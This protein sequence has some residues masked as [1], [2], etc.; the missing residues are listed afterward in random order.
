M[1]WEQLADI[2]NE[3]RQLAQDERDRDPVACPNCGEPLTEGGKAG[4]LFCQF[5]DW[6][7][8][9]PGAPG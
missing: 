7:E 9:Q 4:V 3:G 1:S 2:V 5:G 6:R 8:D